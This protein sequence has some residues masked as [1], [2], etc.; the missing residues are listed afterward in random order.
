MH[1]LSLVMEM[2]DL[3]GE[4]SQE[5]NLKEIHSV[6]VEVGEL[7]GVLADYLGECWNVARI[8]SQFEKTELKVIP[9][10]STALCSCGTEYEMTKNSRICPNCHKTDY[11][12]VKGREFTVKEIEAR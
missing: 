3:V 8:G 11:E 12:I 1:E 5:Q 2:F 7:S 4:I 6:T 10:P 9:I